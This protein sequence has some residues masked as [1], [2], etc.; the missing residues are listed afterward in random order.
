MQFDMGLT[1]LG[2]LL[3][4]SVTFGV[5]VQLVL[6]RRGPFIGAVAGAGWFVG[7][8]VASEVVWG[9]LT[10]EE[11]QPIIDGLTFD[12]AL[13]GGLVGGTLALAAAWLATRPR[14]HPAARA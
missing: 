7:G 2:I 14:T 3:V 8:L 6:G 1:G 4:I 10:V 11:I 12:E 9:G 13:L 5:V